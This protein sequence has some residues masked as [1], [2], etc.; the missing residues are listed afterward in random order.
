MMELYILI[1]GIIIGVGLAAVCSLFRPK[2][3]GKTKSPPQLVYDY[4][5]TDNLT[6]LKDI[7]GWI[8]SSKWELIAVIPRG[9][10]YIVVFRRPIYG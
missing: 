4:D 10:Q 6:T 1:A 7:L 3:T 9:D 2:L 8:N 5:A